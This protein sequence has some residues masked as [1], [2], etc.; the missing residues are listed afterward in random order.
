MARVSVQQNDDLRRISAWVA[1][2]AAPTILAGIDG[3][4]FERMPELG[5]RYGYPAVLVVILL[6]C[7][8]LYVAFRRAGWL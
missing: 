5:W 4:N 2:A 1:I 3:M 8:A 7:A 6:T